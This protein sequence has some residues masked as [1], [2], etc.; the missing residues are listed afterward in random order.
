[1]FVDVDDDLTFSTQAAV[2]RSVVSRAMRVKHIMSTSA[3]AATLTTLLPTRL[4]QT[5]R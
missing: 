4:A 1:M 5:A 2:C 3:V